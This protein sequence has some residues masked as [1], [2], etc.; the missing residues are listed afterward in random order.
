VVFWVRMEGGARYV[1]IDMHASGFDG[2]DADAL[3]KLFRRLF[4]LA[5]FVEASPVIYGEA[6]RHHL[7]STT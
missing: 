4:A 3:R 5:G 7:P 6:T 1:D 2:R